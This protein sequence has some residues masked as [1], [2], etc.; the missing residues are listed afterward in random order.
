MGWPPLGG[1][2]KCLV[3]MPASYDRTVRL[4]DADTGQPFGAPLNGH[5]NQVESVSFSPDGH[6]L[7]S[8]SA[9]TCRL[10]Q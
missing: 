7:V 5:H 1:H 2:A 3:P 10:E 8:G 9:G 4:W 6:R